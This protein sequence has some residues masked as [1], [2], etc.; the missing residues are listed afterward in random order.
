M[1]A[2]SSAMVAAVVVLAIPLPLPLVVEAVVVVRMERL[3]LT[4]MHLRIQL[5][6]ML[7]REVRHRLLSTRQA[8]LASSQSLTRV[9]MGH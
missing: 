3:S 5:L 4:P 2:F 8:T 7:A 6:Y 1:F 9:V